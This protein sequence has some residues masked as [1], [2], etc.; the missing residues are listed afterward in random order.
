MEELLQNTPHFT[1]NQLGFTRELKS[2]LE[3]NPR[4]KY[5]IHVSLELA[6]FYSGVT[7]V[8]SLLYLWFPFLRNFYY[9]V[10]FSVMKS[11]FDVFEYKHDKLYL[12]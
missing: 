3:D 6:L 1:H 7:H 10:I 4:R 2:Y 12:Y 11:L 5:G 8:K 9:S